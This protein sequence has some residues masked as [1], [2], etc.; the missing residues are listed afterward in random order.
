LRVK[1][2]RGE[3]I[4]E[5]IDAWAAGKFDDADALCERVEYTLNNE[6]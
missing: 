6:P 2:L 3:L 4:R 5:A 1:K